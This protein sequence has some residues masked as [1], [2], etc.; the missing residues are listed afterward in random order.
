MRNLSRVNGTQWQQR[1]A[2]SHVWKETTWAVAG[3]LNRIGHQANGTLWPP[4]CCARLDDQ[5]QNGTRT[6]AA[7]NYSF[8]STQARV[9]W[10]A[11]AAETKVASQRWWVLAA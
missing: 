4:R 2:L 3:S 1:Q 11:M 8:A 10:A 6:L 5:V 9:A 7:R